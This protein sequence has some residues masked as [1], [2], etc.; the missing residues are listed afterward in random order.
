M[1][2]SGRSLRVRVAG[3]MWKR[4][5][6]P[7]S[8]EEY[9][10]KSLTALA[11]GDAERAIQ[12]ASEAVERFPDSLEAR[13]LH[14]NVLSFS[15]ETEAAAKTM[16]AL[17]LRHPTSAWMQKALVFERADDLPSAIAAYARAADADP[18]HADAWLGWAT[19]LANNGE[20]ELA[21]EKFERAIELDPKEKI[22]WFNRGNSLSR[23]HRLEEAL[24]SYRKA[25]ELGDENGLRAVRST[26]L[27]LGRISEA[28]AL[29]S[30]DDVQ[31][32]GRERRVTLSSGVAVAARYFVGSHSNPELLDSVVEQLLEHVAS[33]EQKPPGVGDGT[34]IRY[35]WTCLMLRRQGDE[36]V[37]CEPVWQDEP[38]KRYQEHVTFSAM[39]LVQ[40]MVMSELTGAS[41]EDCSC[42]DT[43][44]VER[45]ALAAARTIM[46]R[47]KPESPTDSG[48]ILRCT[49]SEE[50]R[51]ADVPM[52]ALVSA[53]PHFLKAVDLPVGWKAYFDGARLDRVLDDDGKSRLPQ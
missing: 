29:A 27:K 22:A 37:V 49:V 51:G 26:L 11:G 36:L 28:N 38:K 16:D 47:R 15:G 3:P 13:L 17:V 7:R 41:P 52:T 2:G 8:L 24:A 32:E 6:G 35:R 30:S 45:G 53:S 20:H 42:H 1:R 23:L 19:A 5:F 48:W 46:V 44:F 12:L 9:Q 43:I 21:L 4:L 33:L 40:A 18:T 34:V 50:L 39:Q 14:S 25:E 10:K 31:G